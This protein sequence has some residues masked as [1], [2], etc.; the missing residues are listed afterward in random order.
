MCSHKKTEL[1]SKVTS[2]TDDKGR[3]TG[4][5]LDIKLQCVDCKSFFL[6]KTDKVGVLF[7]QPAAS[8]DKEELRIPLTAPSFGAN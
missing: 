5:Q 2:L 6:F 4:W 1:L 8:A 7:D 3:V